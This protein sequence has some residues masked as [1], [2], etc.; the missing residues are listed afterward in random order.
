MLRS[1]QNTSAVTTPAGAL[2]SPEEQYGRHKRGGGRRG[3]GGVADRERRDRLFSASTTLGLPNT[4]PPGGSLLKVLEQTS[5][6]DAWSSRFWSG[7]KSAPIACSLSWR[8]QNPVVNRS[9]HSYGINNLYIIY[10]MNTHRAWCTLDF[11]SVKLICQPAPPRTVTGRKYIHIHGL[12]QSIYC[13][14]QTHSALLS[15]AAFL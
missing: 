12:V 14:V 7:I 2:V 15:A 4:R 11:L 3:G 13:V 10:I 5:S 1:H 9:S 6:A 8:L